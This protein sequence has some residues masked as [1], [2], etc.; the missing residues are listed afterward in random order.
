[1]TKLTQ[2]LRLDLTDT[3][4]RDIKLLTNL[5]KCTASS[6]VKTKTKLNYMLFTR[7][8]CMKLTLDNLAQNRCRCN[9]RWLWRIIITFSS[10]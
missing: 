5:F 3:L 1:M 4:T 2:C 9:F 6:V 8:K 7:S 10:S